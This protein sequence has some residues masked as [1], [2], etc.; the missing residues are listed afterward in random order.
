M[1]RCMKSKNRLIYSLQSLS[2]VLMILSSQSH[3]QMCNSSSQSRPIS[4]PNHIPDTSVIAQV[5]DDSKFFDSADQ[6][7]VAALKLIPSLNNSNYFEYSGCIFVDANSSPHR[8]FYTFPVTNNSSDGIRIS[9]VPPAYATALVGI[10]HTHP[11]SDSFGN[12]DGFSTHDVEIAD[13]LNITSYVG[14]IKT[15]NIIRYIS[16]KS[17][18]ECLDSG[19]TVC[20]NKYSRGERIGIL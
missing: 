12:T 16:C 8:F 20:R 4:V 7:A 1:L 11:I 13:R 10:F 17:R 14:T 2:A 3:A 19:G 6:A 18:K 9:C 5:S 15:R